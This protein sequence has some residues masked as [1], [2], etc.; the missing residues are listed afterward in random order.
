MILFLRSTVRQEPQGV[1]AA[2][3]RR[4]SG[5]W[6]EIFSPEPHGNE[7]NRKMLDEATKATEALGQ[8]Q[9]TKWQDPAQLP[10]VV[11]TWLKDQKQVLFYDGPINGESDITITLDK[12][13]TSLSRSERREIERR[14]PGQGLRTMLGQ[15]M[16]MQKKHLESLDCAHLD[17]FH[18]RFGAVPV[19]TVCTCGEL[20]SQDDRPRFSCMRVGSYV[21]R[22][23]KRCKSAECRGRLQSMRPT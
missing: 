23:S 2:P 11:L 19:Q 8:G 21:C 12:C 17:Y 22:L 7:A 18:N 1:E 9:P 13:K 6:G 15:L 4:H 3:K 5:R 16:L 14:F 10:P 20:K